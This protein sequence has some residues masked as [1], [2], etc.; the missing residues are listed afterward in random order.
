M[1]LH[2]VTRYYYNCGSDNYASIES[3]IEADPL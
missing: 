2:P 3:A 1:E